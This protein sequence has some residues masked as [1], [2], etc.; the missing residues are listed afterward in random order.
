MVPSQLPTYSIRLYFENA[1]LFVYVCIYV[2]KLINWN[3]R[4]ALTNKWVPKPNPFLVTIFASIFTARLHQFSLITLFGL[5]HLLD[6]FW[7]EFCRNFENFC[8]NHYVCWT[9][10]ILTMVSCAL[11][12][13]ISLLLLLFQIWYSCRPSAV[14]SNCLAWSI[15]LAKSVVDAW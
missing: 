8:W 2:Q 12:L 11:S 15:W 9:L 3:G 14:G 5:H 6:K 4:G 1:L 10:S 13:C 7:G